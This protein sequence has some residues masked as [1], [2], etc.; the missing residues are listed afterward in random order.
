MTARTPGEPMPC[1]FCGTSPVVVPWHGGGPRKTMVA[2]ESDDCWIN[3]DVTGSTRKEAI[4]RWNDRDA[5]H[6]KVT[7]SAAK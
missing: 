3:P 1:P 5:A 6:A 2:C 4:R 7:R